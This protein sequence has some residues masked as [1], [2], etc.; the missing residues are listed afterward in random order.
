MDRFRDQIQKEMQN[1]SPW[2]SADQRRAWYKAISAWLYSTDYIRLPSEW[3][4]GRGSLVA[5]CDAPIPPP[6]IGMPALTQ[7][8]R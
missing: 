8:P 2:V 6:S 4:S 5:P 7:Q 1:M 3:V